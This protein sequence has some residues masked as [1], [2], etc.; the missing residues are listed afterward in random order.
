MSM[1]DY[2]GDS[3]F[4][5]NNPNIG[6]AYGSTSG[7]I[8]EACTL[9]ASGTYTGDNFQLNPNHN[10]WDPN[11]N[12]GIWNP[13]PLAPYQEAAPTITLDIHLT[14]DDLLTHMESGRHLSHKTI[15]L[16]MIRQRRI[17]KILAKALKDSNIQD[18]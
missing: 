8:K 14:E 7:P 3:S 5:S 17:E 18:K 12:F 1:A 6:V 16:L 2:L 11:K 13:N 10:I 9:N 4:T 15:L